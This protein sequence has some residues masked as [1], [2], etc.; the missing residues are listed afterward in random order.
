MKRGGGEVGD[1]VVMKVAA[2]AVVGSVMLLSSLAVLGVLLLLLVELELV[3]GLRLR[4][5][6]VLSIRAMVTT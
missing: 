6:V 5:V 1:E 4:L 3:L 2:E